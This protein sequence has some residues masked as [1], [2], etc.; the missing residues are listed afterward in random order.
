MISLPDRNCVSC[1]NCDIPLSQ[2]DMDVLKLA[3]SKKDELERDGKRERSKKMPKRRVQARGQEQ[4]KMIV[5]G[6]SW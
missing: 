1:Q 4:L 6:T 2:N 5:P 3:Q